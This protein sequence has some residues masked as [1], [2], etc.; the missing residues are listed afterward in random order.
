[1]AFIQLEFHER[2]SLLL[3]SV[4]M[5]VIVGWEYP[6]FSTLFDHH[7][8]RCVDKVLRHLSCAPW[9]GLHSS[10]FSRPSA[11]TSTCSL[12]AFA[13]LVAPGVVILCSFVVAAA[14]AS[15]LVA[16]GAWIIAI[17]LIDA[18]VAPIDIMLRL[19]MLRSAFAMIVG[20]QFSGGHL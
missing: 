12:V 17:L 8:K 1:M 6:C 13:Q 3:A 15:A 19:S 14:A 18:A 16:G 20:G 9:A 5:P 7:I 11:S 2:L 4:I 10:T